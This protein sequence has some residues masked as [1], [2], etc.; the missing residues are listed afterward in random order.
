VFAVVCA[1]KRF[2]RFRSQTSRKV[3]SSSQG[4][5][6]GIQL[7]LMVPLRSPSMWRKG[8]SEGSAGADA[9]ASGKF[10]VVSFELGGSEGVES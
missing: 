1:C 2:F 9:S 5:S 3:S 10:L 7:G 8:S 4:I 6:A